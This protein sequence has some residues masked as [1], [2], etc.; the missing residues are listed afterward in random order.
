MIEKIVSTGN[1]NIIAVDRGTMFGYQQLVSD[2]RAI[3]IMQKLGVPVC[4]DATHSV[5]LPGGLGDRSGGQREFIPV[6]A[7]AAVAA[8]TDC[9]FIESHPNPQEAKSDAASMLS[10]DDFPALLEQ[11]VRL[12]QV[13]H[14]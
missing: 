14:E 6:L 11:L 13:V 7:K 9:L 10:I 12:Y 1:E 8:G 2:F 4:F 3:P 5:Q